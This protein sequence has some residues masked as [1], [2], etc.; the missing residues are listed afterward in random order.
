M[1]ETLTMAKAFEFVVQQVGV[2]IPD[3]AL[4]AA[5]TPAAWHRLDGVG[6]LAPGRWADL[7]LVDDDGVLHGVMRRGDWVVPVQP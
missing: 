7:C 4:M 3:A 5:T 6:V 1:S 2:S